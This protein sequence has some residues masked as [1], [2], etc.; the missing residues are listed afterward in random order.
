MVFFRVILPCLKHAVRREYSS[1]MMV[2]LMKKISGKK[3]TLRLHQNLRGGPGNITF[4]SF[5]RSTTA[6]PHFRIGLLVEID[7]CSG[8]ISNRERELGGK[9]FS[10]NFTW[11]TD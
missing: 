7:D 11:R 5:L 2:V 9:I 10:R 1:L 8:R 4:V 6:E 3:N